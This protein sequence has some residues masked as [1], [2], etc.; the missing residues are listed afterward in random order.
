[1]H[2]ATGVYLLPESAVLH[3]V[4]L[5]LGDHLVGDLAEKHRHAL[6]CAVVSRDRQHHLGVVHQPLCSRRRSERYFKIGSIMTLLMNIT[7][8]LLA[9]PS[10]TIVRQDM[11]ISSHCWKIRE[12][13]TGSSGKGVYDFLWLAVI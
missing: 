2:N 10:A 12:H 6:A 3:E 9:A 4:L 13:R 7:T 11:I 8:R 5:A 1:M